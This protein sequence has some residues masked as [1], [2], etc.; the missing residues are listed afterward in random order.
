MRQIRCHRFPCVQLTVFYDI[1]CRDINIT[2]ATKQRN[3]ERLE[4]IMQQGKVD[5]I[6][7]SRPLICEPDLPLR[8]IKGQGKSDAAYHEVLM[9]FLFPILYRP[10][11][12]NEEYCR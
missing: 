5:F 8:W 6:A 12:Y 11:R 10:Y 9:Q 7:M 2:M 3:F 1:G 4:E